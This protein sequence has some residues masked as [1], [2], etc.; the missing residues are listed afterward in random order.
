MFLS[1]QD[2]DKS[3]KCTKSKPSDA[4]SQCLIR[5]VKVIKIQNPRKNAPRIIHEC[6]ELPNPYHVFI[7]THIRYIVSTQPASCHTPNLLHLIQSPPCNSASYTGPNSIHDVL[8]QIPPFSTLLPYHRYNS[9]NLQSLISKHNLHPFTDSPQ[10]HQ[11]LPA[12]AMI[13]CFL[14]HVSDNMR[15]VYGVTSRRKSKSTLT[16]YI[17]T[18]KKVSRQSPQFPIQ[19]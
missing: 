5:K 4:A 14:H 13:P 10:P 16:T 3:H 1:S 7:I 11:L 18:Y 15:Q 6:E 12:A 2:L 19:F 8:Q 17:N 9:A